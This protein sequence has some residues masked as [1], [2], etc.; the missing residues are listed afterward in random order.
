MAI[1]TPD[2]ERDLHR[3]EKADTMHSENTTDQ[4]QRDADFLES[5][6]DERRRAVVR[7]VDVSYSKA[8]VQYFILL[9]PTDAAH[10]YACPSV[11]DSIPG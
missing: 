1:H 3:D 2:I 8:A 6:P 10:P 11:P 4:A 5:F 7:K 9:T